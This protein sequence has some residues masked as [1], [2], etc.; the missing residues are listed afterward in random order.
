MSRFASLHSGLLAR[1][2][3]ALPAAPNRLAAAYY[4]PEPGQE[5]S[6]PPEA[7]PVDTS[8]SV[9]AAAPKRT[10]PE[11]TSDP[12]TTSGP[13]LRRT[14]PQSKPARRKTTLR[15]SL[16]QH[17]R[18]RIAAAQLDVSQQNLMSAALEAYLD[19]ISDGQFPACS[20]LDSR[21]G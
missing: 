3:E 17:R 20:C 10:T 9:R 5:A 7:P 4:A 14:A 13:K 19:Q 2:G 1:K 11:T 21:D 8:K 12:K 18:L 16:D 6:D 15:L